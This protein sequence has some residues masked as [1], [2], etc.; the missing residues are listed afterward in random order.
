MGKYQQEMA[1]MFNQELPPMFQATIGEV[2]EPIPNLIISIFN[3][4]V[5]LY[6]D[7]LY[8]NNRLFNDYTR[9]YEFIGEIEDITIGTTSSNIDSNGH[10]HFHGTIEGKGE[11]S[12]KGI[13]TNTDTLV[14]GDRVVVFPVEEGQIWIVG[15]KIRKVKA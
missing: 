13:I 6:P 10:I 15:F 11:I 7:M 3:N 14:K 4:T 8:M 5:T 2:V 9:D 1:K 12:S